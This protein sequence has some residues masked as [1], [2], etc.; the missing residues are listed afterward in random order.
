MCR[1]LLLLSGLLAAVDPVASA[2]SPDIAAERAE[3]RP[4]WQCDLMFA[5]DERWLLRCDDLQAQ[6]DFDPAWTMRRRR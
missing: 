5:P 1:A 3:I 2:Q 6:T 4:R